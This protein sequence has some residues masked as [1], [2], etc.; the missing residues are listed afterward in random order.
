MKRRNFLKLIAAAVVCPKGL[1]VEKKEPWAAFRKNY[2]LSD[3]EKSE[4]VDKIRKAFKNTKFK[5][6]CKPHVYYRG[7]RYYRGIWCG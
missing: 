1:L 6:P 3:A 7:D 2:N 4:L 5:S